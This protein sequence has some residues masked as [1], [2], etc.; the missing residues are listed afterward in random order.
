MADVPPDPI[1]KAPFR[2]IKS[3]MF[4]TTAHFSELRE[5]SSDERGVSTEA[6]KLGRKLLAG[7]LD[8]D[9]ARVA[10]ALVP[11]AASTE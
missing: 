10:L 4:G 9:C 11:E 8:V 3:D 6:A 7:I 5:N 2:T 1:R